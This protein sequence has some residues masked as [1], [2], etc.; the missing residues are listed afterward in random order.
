MQAILQN[1]F[2]KYLYGFL[3]NPTTVIFFAVTFTLGMVF[4]YGTI[5]FVNGEPV[6]LEQ[7]WQEQ[8][9]IG[10]EARF[11]AANNQQ[12]ANPENIVNLLRAVDDPA[13]IA[14]ELQLGNAEFQQLAQQAQEQADPAPRGGTI[15]SNYVMPVV[16]VIVFTIVYVV[17]YFVWSFVIFPFIRDLT[18]K[19]DAAEKEAASKQIQQIKDRRALEEQMKAEATSSEGTIKYGEAVIQKVSMYQRGFGKYDDSFN[20]ETEDKT[21]YGE[22]GGAIAETIGEDGVTALEVWMFDKDDFTNTPTT[23]L[24][25]QYAFNDPGLKSRLDPRGDVVMAEP[26]VIVKLET[27]AVYVEAK[28]VEVI[29]DETADIPNSV[30]KKVVTQVTAWAKNE[31]TASGGGLP[32]MPSPTPPSAPTGV[33]VPQAPPMGGQMGGSQPPMPGGSGPATPPPEDPF[34]GT[35]D[36]TPVN[37]NR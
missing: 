22:A 26:G 12:A 1:P 31:N 6:Q 32:P 23:I 7:S 2:L 15:I 33:P 29:Y 36:F 5:S 20:I 21:Y 27:Q 10:V 24:A 30:F 3:P 14:Q 28:V 13:T 37:P 17:L 11:R 25:S 8:W 4:A 16:W 18:R 35:G 19:E 9:V 34:G